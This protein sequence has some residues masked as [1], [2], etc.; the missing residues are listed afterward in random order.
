MNWKDVVIKTKT[1][2]RERERNE[3]FLLFEAKFVAFRYDKQL[4][5]VTR[6]QNPLGTGSDDNLQRLFTQDDV[7]T[8][9]QY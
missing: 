7:K 8:P 9:F 2:E 6:R 4:P 1:A 3:Q 5:F